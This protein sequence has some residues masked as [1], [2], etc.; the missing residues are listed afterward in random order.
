M[1]D[2]RIKGITIELDGEVTGLQK[3]LADVTKQSI[4]IQKELKDVDRLLKFDPSNVEAMAQKQK[5]LASQIEVTSEKLSR[6]KAVEE[7][8]NEQFSKGEI[9]E[10][11]FRAFRREI[12]Y[13]EGSLDKLKSSLAKI[14]DVGSVEKV[15]TN[16]SEIPEESEKAEGSIKE[17]GGELTE[18][19]AGAA[20]VEG[21]NELMEKAFEASS[22]NTKISISMELDEG[23]QQAVKNAISSVTAYGVDAEAALE[24]VRRQWALNKDA[25]DESNAAVVKAAATIT[26]AY[27]DID[28]TEL[29]QESNELSK[30]LNISNEDAMGLVY[31]LLKMGFPP[32]QLDVITEYGSQLS[33]AGYNAQEIQGIMAAGV[34]A[35][36]WNIDVLLDGLKEGRI[37]LAEFGQGVSDATAGLLE[38]TNISATQLQGWGKAVA[39]GGET[40]K[41][42][43]SDVA[44]AVASIDDKTKQNALGV[45]I[46]GTQWEEN[47]TKITDT[48]LGMNDNL[49][50]AEANQNNLN[51]AIQ[52][53]NADPAIKMQ[54]AI[55]SLTTALTPLLLGLAQV[56]AAVAGWISENPNLSAAIIAV[57][58]AIAI[59]G[60]ICMGLM[61][62]FT[63]I[64]T[65][66]ELF[67][68]ELAV[69]SGPIGIAIAAIVALI[70]VG[71]LLY[72]NWDE[73][74]AKAVEIWTYLQGWLA[75]AWQQITD[76]ATAAWLGMKKFFA[77][78]LESIKADAVEIWQS[79][80]SFFTESIPAWIKQIDKWFSNL[81]YL[82]AYYLG[83]AIG[84]IIKWGTDSW[85]YLSTNVPLWI[86][87]IG[88]FFSELPETIWT[89]LLNVITKFANWGGSI[90]NWIATNV[91]IWINSIVSY[92]IQLPP[93][94]WNWLVQCVDNIKT[95][96]INMLTEAVNG[97]EQVFNGIVDIF[98]KL[99]DRMFEIGSNIVAGIKNGISD[100]WEG[101]KDWMAGLADDFADG[102]AEA[103]DIHSPSRVMMKLGAFA[104]EGFELGVK[105]TFGQITKQSQALADAAIPDIDTA[106]T[107]ALSSG[108]NSAGAGINQT[109]NIYSP[110]ALSPA[111]TARQN[112]KALQELAF[113][114]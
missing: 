113:A 9:G 93:A 97:A 82:I 92:F 72:K 6:L 41:K 56:A 100:A 54:E 5:L 51:A 36:S 11:Q 99:P 106:R 44:A 67:G 12:E 68:V 8:V 111:E 88:N 110:A 83:Y 53:L 62:I 84:S 63:A 81:P 96:G 60:G 61:P 57:V 75:Q 58:S 39:A 114:L 112:K 3:A 46:F 42:A 109:V 22:T 87:G 29:I 37:R 14:D 90:V 79:I 2:S 35:G 70:A 28:F 21:I 43:M 48:I 7:Q 66:A 85:T 38:G 52:D 91:P 27:G 86:E 77:Q 18:L 76:T 23:S 108:S 74:S 34:K 40:G 78:T 80:V 104:G 17:L 89:W 71:V 94:I 24:G 16:L 50:T 101:M 47:G 55:N 49:M 69:I 107:A 10:A 13:T 26:A 32:D 98:K 65:A 19:L 25:S 33:R 95:W 15:K 73:I 64:T 103:L 59:L 45:A 31:S 1:A 105:S 4:D 30:S 20:A 102:V